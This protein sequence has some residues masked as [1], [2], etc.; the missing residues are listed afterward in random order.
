MCIYR[1]EGPVVALHDPH[2]PGRQLTYNSVAHV[3]T[4]GLGQNRNTF[5]SGVLCD[6][7][8]SYFGNTLEG[9]LIRH[10]QLA[11]DM[12]K[13]RVPGK[14]GRPR[15]VIGN[16][17]RTAD[18]AFEV[19]TVVDDGGTHLGRPLIVGRPILDRKFDALEF[20]R[21]LHLLAFN[22]LAYLY[23]SGQVVDPFYDP[24]AS[25][26][27]AV[28]TYVRAPRSPTEAW[29]FIECYDPPLSGGTMKVDLLQWGDVL[30]GKVR[31][32][33]YEFYVDL[34]NTGSIGLWAQGQTLT[35]AR[36]IEPGV[37]YPAS[38]RLEEVPPE[39]RAW[40][41]LDNWG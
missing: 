41:R 8:N 23:A 30:I 14:N 26:Y 37:R 15:T 25:R 19:R 17:R 40:M 36:L 13:L 21:G 11:L 12:H 28:R 1:S 24:R 35:N 18:G 31:A 29:P 2:P 16:W 38:P 22:V 27:D 32:F 4:Q 7:C 6:K 3:I 10:P 9:A 20:R 39:K 34:M 33:S 5:P